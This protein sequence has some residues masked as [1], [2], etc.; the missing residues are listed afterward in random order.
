[1]SLGHCVCVCVWS[2]DLSKCLCDPVCVCVWSVDLS[3]CFCDTVC[4]CGL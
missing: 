2:V 1:M 4:V 3:K